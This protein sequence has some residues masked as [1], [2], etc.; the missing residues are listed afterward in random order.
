[1]LCELNKTL[2]EY[3]QSRISKD[4]QGYH[5]DQSVSTLNLNNHGYLDVFSQKHRL[6]C[7][8]FFKALRFIFRT[9]TAPQLFIHIVLR[10]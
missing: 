5:F 7:T 3:R 1:M 8:N 10:E 4:K 2:L 9:I 6:F